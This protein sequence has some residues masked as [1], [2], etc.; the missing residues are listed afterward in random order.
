MD[1]K[2]KISKGLRL[3]M[4]KKSEEEPFEGGK[5]NINTKNC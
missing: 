3:S 1:R 4:L 5:R 2:R